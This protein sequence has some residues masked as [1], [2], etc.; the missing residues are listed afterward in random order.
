MSETLTPLYAQDPAKGAELH[1]RLSAVH[2]EVFTGGNTDGPATHK[3]R[4]G[5]EWDITLNTS[6]TGELCAASLDRLGQQH[7]DFK[8]TGDE[9]WA[10]V[11]T[12]QLFPWAHFPT[13]VNMATSRGLEWAESRQAGN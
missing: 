11:E 7:H 13:L 1:S 12:G 2:Q 5:N 3:A 8:R 4:F 10:V 6:D 9:T